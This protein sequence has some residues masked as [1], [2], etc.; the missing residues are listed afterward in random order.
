M[1]ILSAFWED[2]GKI[3]KG[4]LRSLCRVEIEQLDLLRLWKRLP[5]PEEDKYDLDSLDSQDKSDWHAY[6]DISIYY[7]MS[8]PALVSP[9]YDQLTPFDLIRLPVRAVRERGRAK[10]G[11]L[12]LSP[13]LLKP[14]ATRLLSPSIE[15]RAS[16]PATWMNFWSAAAE[17]WRWLSLP[18]SAWLIWKCAQFYAAYLSEQLER[19]WSRLSES[20]QFFF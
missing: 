9:G 13:V 15:K 14:K 16:R 10:G 2:Y 5:E 19:K 8:G 1:A 18:V 6:R 20:R 11:Y 7:D 4:F 12:S 17:L 3:E